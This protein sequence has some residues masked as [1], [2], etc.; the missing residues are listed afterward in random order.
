M[1]EYSIKSSHQYIIE[2]EK[3]TIFQVYALHTGITES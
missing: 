2:A 1:C 3:I